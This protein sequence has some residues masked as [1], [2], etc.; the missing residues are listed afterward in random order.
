[1]RLT[2]EQRKEDELIC[3]FIILDTDDSRVDTSGVDNAIVWID[4]DLRDVGFEVVGEL[5]H[6]SAM[7]GIPDR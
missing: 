6:Q 1:M 5:L 2:S 3:P 7:S 4:C